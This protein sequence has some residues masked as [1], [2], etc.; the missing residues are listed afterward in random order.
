MWLVIT[1]MSPAAVKAWVTLWSRKPSLLICS[2]LW[3]L[4][5]K[6]VHSTWFRSPKAPLDPHQQSLKWVMD[7]LH[8]WSGKEERRVWCIKIEPESAGAGDWELI[9]DAIINYSKHLIMVSHNAVAQTHT[10]TVTHTQ[11]YVPQAFPTVPLMADTQRK[12][13][14]WRGHKEKDYCCFCLVFYWHTLWHTHTVSHK[15]K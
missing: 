6:N 14:G 4:P 15:H 13:D 1:R 3:L 5:V 11:R 8:L 7:T 10:C 12:I 9:R 2:L